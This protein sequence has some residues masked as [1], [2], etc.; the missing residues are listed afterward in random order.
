MHELMQPPDASTAGQAV[1]ALRVWIIDGKPQF[2]LRGN[3]WSENA[4]LWGRLLADVAQH[5]ADA[6]ATETRRNREG[7]LSEI[8]VAFSA[9]VDIPTADSTGAFFKHDA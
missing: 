8:A 9:E 7:L 5:L 1:E 2:V 6:L 3:M 4:A